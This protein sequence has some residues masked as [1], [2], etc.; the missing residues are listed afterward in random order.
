MRGRNR[1]AELPPAREALFGFKLSQ[2]RTCGRPIDSMLHHQRSDSIRFPRRKRDSQ[3]SGNLS[4]DFFYS[5]RAD[6][7]MMFRGQAGNDRGNRVRVDFVRDR[8]FAAELLGCHPSQRSFGNEFKTE[9]LSSH[10]GHFF[11]AAAWLA[12][13]SDDGHSGP[14]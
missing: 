6:H 2:E 9:P 13:H 11:R 5:L 1:P 3:G 12:R 4:G 8:R 14:S 7:K 10:A